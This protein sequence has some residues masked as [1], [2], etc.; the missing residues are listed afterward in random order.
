MAIIHYDLTTRCQ[1]EIFPPEREDPDTDSKT[2]LCCERRLQ[3]S[4]MDDDACAICEEC[5][6]P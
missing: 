2:C 3:A 5:L 6:S 4:C 1:V